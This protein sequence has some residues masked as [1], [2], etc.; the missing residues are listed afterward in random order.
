MCILCSK[1]KKVVKCDQCTK[2]LYCSKL[3]RNRDYANHRDNVCPV[4]KD[5]CCQC[6]KVILQGEECNVIEN[7]SQGTNSFYCME[8][9]GNVPV[10]VEREDS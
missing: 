1:D 6:K 7:R 2:L 8:C 4:G 10:F 5:T 3:C 9:S